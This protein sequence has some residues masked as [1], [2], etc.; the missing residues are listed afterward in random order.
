IQ[1]QMKALESLDIDYAVVPGVSSFLAAAASLKQ[2]LTLPGVSQTV[3]LTR[4]GEKTPVPEKESLK[5]LAQARAT[6]CL[7]LSARQ[8][9]KAVEEL[10]PFY[11]ADC[12]AAVIYKS[13]W[14]EEKIIRAPLSELAQKAGKE[15]IKKTALVIVGWVLAKGS[16]PAAFERSRVYQSD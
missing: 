2:E 9:K 11:G 15:G 1:E 8:L 16:G 10:L 4:L 14:K 5:T 13:T 3:I 6:L 12:P 7:F